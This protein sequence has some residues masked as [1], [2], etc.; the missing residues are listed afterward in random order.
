MQIRSVLLV[1]LFSSLSLLSHAFPLIPQE[2]PTKSALRR[3]V[4][5]SV[6]A[7]DGGSAATSP[8][9]NGNPVQTIIQTSDQTETVTALAS[10]PLP[11]TEIVVSTIMVNESQPAKTVDVS[12][13]KVTTKAFSP[14][15]P[16]SSKV[17]NADDAAPFPTVDFV[18]KTSTAL[19]TVDCTS[20]SSSTFS[21][22]ST[23]MPTTTSKISLTTIVPSTPP[24]YA[25]PGT[26]TGAPAEA[27]W[28]APAGLLPPPSSTLTSYITQPTT[29]SKTYDD[30]MWHT[31][32]RTWNA[33]STMPSS[34]STTA[35]AT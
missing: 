34:S 1:Y 5:Y 22:S 32:W 30:G 15:S 12:I 13:T 35:T 20:S 18:T 24:Q 25:K 6:V 7:V 4:A 28:V 26:E 11:S 14:T 27:G 8:T 16:P 29:T 19:T 10:T 33:T 3:R 31:T 21:T 23:A 2:P 17:V 9:A